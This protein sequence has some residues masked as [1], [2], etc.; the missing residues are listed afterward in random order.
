MLRNTLIFICAVLLTPLASMT[1]ASAQITVKKTLSITGTVESVSAAGL[2][3][4]DDSGKAHTVRVQPVDQ[5]NVALA[6]GRLLR[7]PAEI[8]VIGNY[9]IDDLKAGQTIQFQGQVNR[10]GR[11]AGEIQNISLVSGAE[12]SS[13]IRVIE[14]ASGT[15]AF[16]TCEIVCQFTRVSNG[17]LLVQVPANN[18]FTR[19]Q[20]LSFQLADDATVSFQSNDI[21]RA[22]AGSKVVRLEAARLNTGDLVA[23]AVEIE[24]GG[25]TTAR[26]SVDDKLL[27][28]YRHLSD[29]PQPPRLVRSS[30]FAFMTDV[31]DRQARIILDKLET[32]AGLLTKYFGRAP[33]G[34]VE[35]FVVRDLSGWPNGLLKEP[36]GI[37]KIESGA[38]ICFNSSLG[39]QRRAVLYS[40][41]DHGVVQHECTHGFCYLA[42]GSTGPTWLSEGVAEMGQYWKADQLAVNVS[43]TVMSY[44]QRAEPKKKLLEIAVPGRVDAGTWQD[45]AWRWALCHLLANNPNYA[46]RF[47]PLA[48]A[49]MEKR[50]GVSFAAVY[51]PVAQQ[52]A[53]EYDLFLNTLDNGYRADLCAWQW[54]ER[55]AALQGSRRMQKKIAAAY[56]WQA[57]GVTLE[58]AVSYDIASVGTWKIA[59]DGSEYDADGDS[60]GR[61]KLVG[62]IFDDFQL[63]DPIPIGKLKRLEAVSDGQLYLRCQDD[64]NKLADNEGELTVHVRRTPES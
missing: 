14:E 10:V 27:A 35:G 21:R 42:F 60:D 1:S 59:Q 23:K 46:D 50:E 28:R 20:V 37:A 31:S 16:F 52:I 4:K 41:D 8:Q 48:I 22:A 2:V 34:V 43:P 9:T 15:G 51:G 26:A 33:T 36:A 64:W 61:G 32:M 49:L 12:A 40:C 56:G 45:Y 63:S 39:S 53:F 47:K 58:K 18:G 5:E 25:E 6:D 17:R 11:T 57:S 19:K 7:F 38:G 44:L 54:N 62:V 29:E 30:H 55:F 24:I 13:G 3:V